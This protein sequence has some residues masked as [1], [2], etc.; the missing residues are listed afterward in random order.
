MKNNYPD[1]F[2]TAAELAKIIDAKFPFFW[3]KK[4]L[5]NKQYSISK[6]KEPKLKNKQDVLSR[7]SGEICGNLTN[8]KNIETKLNYKNI[9]IFR[10]TTSSKNSTTSDNANIGN[11]QQKY[12]NEQPMQQPIEKPEINKQEN[13]QESKQEN[14][15]E[16]NSNNSCKEERQ[17]EDYYKDICKTLLKE[18]NIYSK[19]INALKSSC[20]KGDGAAKWLHPDIIGVKDTIRNFEDCVKNL[21]SNKE[22]LEIYSFEVK[23]DLKMSNL[24]EIF[25]QALSNSSW[26]NY[27]YLI[28]INLNEQN[29]ELMEELQMLCS[30]YNIGVIKYDDQNKSIKTLFY[31]NKKELNW[32]MINRLAEENNSDINTVLENIDSFYQKPQL[33]YGWDV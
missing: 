22:R 24:K 10:Y 6:G 30:S 29:K 4:L 12:N 9:T 16:H 26:A 11:E 8:K 20:K 21:I 1:R 17:E 32:K 31:A 7:M 25:F 2:F 5:A 18:K 27:G 3:E 23:K 14:C 19:I 15:N 13:K 33:K 28:F